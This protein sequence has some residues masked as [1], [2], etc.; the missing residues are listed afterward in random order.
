MGYGESYG[1][2]QIA[3]CSYG[4][5]L[6]SMADSCGAWQIAVEHGRYSCVLLWQ[7]HGAVEYW[8]IT[9]EYGR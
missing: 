1:A 2:W 7:I 8:Q 5:L 6:W 4:R 9:V 3:V